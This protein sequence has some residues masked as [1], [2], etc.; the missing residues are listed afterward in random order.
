EQRAVVLSAALLHDVGHG[1]FSHAFESITRDKHEKRTLEMISDERTEIHAALTEFSADLPDHLR[2]FFDDDPEVEAS[3][4]SIVP[5]YL[6]QI[7]SSQL[8][9]DRFDYLLRDSYSTGTEYGRFDVEWLLQ[10]LDIDGDKQRFF[11]HD[12]AILAAETY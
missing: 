10:H 5:P 11:L 4:E 7:V 1:P 8:D 2:L 9:A 3:G 6:T 12:K